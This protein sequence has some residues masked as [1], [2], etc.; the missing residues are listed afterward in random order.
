MKRLITAELV[1]N[2]EYE[3]D[4]YIFRYNNEEGQVEAYFPVGDSEVIVDYQPLVTPEEWN[5]DHDE[6]INDLIQSINAE[7]E[8]IYQFDLR[9]REPEF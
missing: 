9:D 8:D 5:E 6:I 2:E 1:Q 4:G 3:R 7:W